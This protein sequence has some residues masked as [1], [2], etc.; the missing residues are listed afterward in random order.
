MYAKKKSACARDGHV[1]VTYAGWGR[2][3]KEGVFVLETGM[4]ALG[5]VV[6]VRGAGCLATPLVLALLK[7]AVPLET[8]VT[9]VARVNRNP[10]PRASFPTSRRRR[11]EG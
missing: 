2:C 4:V 8:G 5:R 3:Y 6:F 7:R 10:K 9:V 1:C 11:C